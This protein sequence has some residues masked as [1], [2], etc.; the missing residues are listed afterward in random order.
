MAITTVTGRPSGPIKYTKITDSSA[1]WASVAN[2]TYFYDK[3]EQLVHYKD[4]SGAVLSLF[5]Y[6]AYADSVVVGLYDDRGNY[7]ASVNAY[8]SSGGSGTAGAILKGD[9]WTVSVAGV[10]P[11]GQEVEVGDLVR[12]LVDSPGNTA[13]NWAITQSNIAYGKAAIFSSAGVPTY[14]S[15][16]QAAINAA[17]AGDTVQLFANVTENIVL[18]NG[19]NIN[20]NGFTLTGAAGGGT[21]TMITTITCDLINLKI[22]GS[23]GSFY[24]VN[25]SNNSSLYFKNTICSNS[26][27]YSIN[28]QVGCNVYNLDCINAG[29]QNAGTINGGVVRTIGVVVGCNNTGIVKNLV[30]YAE[31]GIAL[32]QLSGESYNVIGYSNSHIAIRFL[33]GKAYFCKG[34]SETSAGIY[35]AGSTEEYNCVA[36]SNGNSTGGIFVNPIDCIGKSNTGNG[37]SAPKAN[38]CI[39]ISNTDLGFTAEEG[40]E[41]I[42]CKSI[43]RN[44]WGMVLSLTTTPAKFIDC[45][46]ISGNNASDG[47]ALYIP[48]INSTIASKFINCV[49]K[50]KHASAYAIYA[51]NAQ[52]IYLSNCKFDSALGVHVNVTNIETRTADAQGNMFVN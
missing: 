13:S 40:G 37:F 30:S 38:R 36:I 41:Y 50:T 21:V 42:S 51:A 39:G 27:G 16:L 24:A 17:S 15:S 48:N 4:N 43:S 49:F 26:A 25:V 11:T 45:I 18:K 31:N 7:D 12:A 5:D 22:S 6:K 47:H 35:S 8:P 32:D 14:Y 46:F 34:V 10:L 2:N 9:I 33:G 1:D 23:G 28:N 44:Q 19:V 52:N 20:G 29:V 3:A